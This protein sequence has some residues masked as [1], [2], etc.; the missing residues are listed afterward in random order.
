M[1]FDTGCQTSL[2]SEQFWRDSLGSPP[3]QRSKHVFRSYTN[4]SFQP[5]GEIILDL[6]YH[7][8]VLKHPFQVVRNDDSLF[9]RDLMSKIQIDWSEVKSQVNRVTNA[10]NNIGL[11]NILTEFGDVFGP[12]QGLIKDFTAKVSLKDDAVPRF[13]KARPIPYALKA[14]V[15]EEIENM[16]RKGILSKIDHSEWASPLVVVPKANGKIRITGDFKHTVNGQLN[17]TQYPLAKPEEIFANISGGQF[18]TKLDGPDAF[19]QIPLDE[20]SKQFLVVNT[21]RGLYRYNVLPMGIS[22]APAIFQEF[23]DKMIRGIPMSGAFMDDCI[24]TGKNDDEHCKILRQVL[25]RMREANY[26]LN[27]DKCAFFQP[28]VEFLG[29]VVSSEGLHTSPQKV[30]AIKEMPKPTNASELSSFLGLVNFYRNFVHRFSDFC[31]PLYKLTQQGV[32][33]NWTTE[34]QR[35]FEEVKRTLCSTEVLAHFDM[36]L[37]IGISCDASPVGLGIVLFH[38]YPDGTERPISYASRTLTPT[39]RRYPQI[40]REALGIFYGCKKY[41]E[42]LCGKKFTLV[43]DH[44]PF[45]CIF[46]PSKQV[47]SFTASRI[48]KWSQYLSQF[49]FDVVYRNTKK[50]GNADALSRLPIP[51]PKGESDEDFVSDVHMVASTCLDQLPVTCKKIRNFTK[52]DKVLSLVLMYIQ[53]GWPQS[54]PKTDPVY[55]CYLR[56]NELSIVQG[57]IMWGVRVVIPLALQPQ[58]LEQL[59]AEHFGIVRMKSLARQFIWWSGIDADI[60]RI[61]Q[62]CKPCQESAPNPQSAPLHPWEFPERAWQRLHVDLAGPFLGKTWLVVMDAHSKWPEVFNLENNSTS[63]SVIRRLRECFTRFGIPEQIVSDNGRQ[64]V[65]KEFK[66]FCT[67]NNI[68]LTTSSVYHPRSNGE[69][70]RFVRTFKNAM[71]KASSKDWELNLHRFILTYRITPHATTGSAPSE[72]LQGRR[73]RCLLD[74][75]RPDPAATTLES[76]QRQ[77]QSFNKSAKAREFFVGQRVW[78]KTFSSNLP[79]WSLGTIERHKGP[80][81][82]LVS[83]NDISYRRHHDQI[84]DAGS[85]TLPKVKHVPDKDPALPDEYPEL[86]KA[87]AQPRTPQAAE[88]SSWKSSPAS[89]ELNWF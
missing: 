45:L 33:W 67:G 46:G 9:G 48:H 19:H 78:V 34:C 25:L 41:Y 85:G 4:T 43:T 36:E 35:A 57:V 59:H 11:Q 1:E 87:A 12:T 81:T 21:P 27:K 82:C 28:T 22:S 37:P 71:S 53:D 23:M 26:R 2:L 17:V 31:E 65:S 24:C 50:H 5:L 52:R 80:V 70:E 66:D 60:K 18:F 15:D 61:S 77:E 68:K 62:N 3:L 40:E 42:F 47:P 8:Q 72:L 64:F 86:P 39:E 56:K 20:S 79:L 89:L 55:A 44:E 10:N 14:K 7:G 88:D 74:L 73:L 58:L 6:D 54:V 32:D 13:L 38:K 30:T 75:V 63:H 16:E 69:A 84:R 29:Y 49:R 76:Q 51:A 83:V